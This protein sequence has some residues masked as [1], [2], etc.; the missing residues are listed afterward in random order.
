MIDRVDQAMVEALAE[1]TD[2]P[3]V[4]IHLPT[5]RLGPDRASKIRLRNLLAEA[6][7]TLEDHGT[8]A[9]TV[10]AFRHHSRHRAFV[11]SSIKGNVSH[12][13]PGALHQRAIPLI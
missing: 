4:S 5:E 12:L 1:R 10:A 8:D 7:S 2:G 13:T 6:R 3:W 9:Q 11:E